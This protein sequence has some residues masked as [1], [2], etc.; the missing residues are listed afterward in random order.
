M[1]EGVNA[2]YGELF[3]G[4]RSCP[5]RSAAW[6][7]PGW[8]TIPRPWRR[9]SGWGS[10]SPAAVAD[11]IRAWHHGRI[12]ATRTERGRELFTRLAP[13]LLTALARPAPPDAAFQP[14]RRLLRRA[15]RRGC[16]SSPCSWPSRELFE[17]IVGVMAFAPR[18]AR[19][20]AAIRRRWTPCWTRASRPSWASTPACSTRWRRRPQ[21]PATS[22]AA[23]DAVRRLHREQAFRIGVQVM[24]GRIGAEGGGAGLRRPGRR[25]PAQRWRRRRWRGRAARRGVARRGGG[26]RA[27]QGR[28]ARDDA[29]ARTWT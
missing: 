12:P 1:L 21:T 23:M 28:V 11:T 9:W 29:P 17:L 5:R 19:R 8:R 14:L 20:W 26:H 4:R 16:R 18:L 2:R 10:P 24:T 15:C 6:C 7:S 25:C 3:E 27:G 13:R 22:K